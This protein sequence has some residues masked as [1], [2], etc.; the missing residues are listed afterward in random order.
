MFLHDI[1]LEKGACCRIKFDKTI[2]VMN[3]NDC[4]RFCTVFVRK[5]APAANLK[6]NKN[7]KRMIVALFLTI[8]TR[9]N[10]PAANLKGNKNI[11]SIMFHHLLTT[12][13]EKNA[14]AAGLR[15]DTNGLHR[16][17][18]DLTGLHWNSSEFIELY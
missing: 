15:H 1:Q 6:G 17:S 18:P 10:A 12:F 2:K 4:Y 11:K 14:P 3:F 5:N 7:I 13:T 9:K 8:L 16:S